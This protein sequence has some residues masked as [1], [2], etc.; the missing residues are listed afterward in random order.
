MKGTP[1]NDA[2]V[3]YMNALFP[4]EDELLRQ[5]KADAEAAGIPAIQISPEQAACMQVLLRA[6]NAKRVLEVGT[7]AGYS[8]IVMARAMGDGAR[9]ITVERDP[10]HAEFAREYIDRA[11]LSSA[12]EVKIGSGLDVLERDLD[13]AS[14]FD[15]AFIDADKPAYARYLELI[16]PKMRPGGLVAGDNALAWGEIANAQTDREDVRG[17]QAFNQ[18]MAS[19]P[20]IVQ[21][22]ILPVGDGMC[23]GTVAP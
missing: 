17:M 20:R 16:I 18:A 9:V 13:G 1:L 22:C 7:L 12:I 10:M 23:I 8:A 2:T 21:A 5:L 14:A 4:A 15:F 11:G 19:H 6:V 3:E